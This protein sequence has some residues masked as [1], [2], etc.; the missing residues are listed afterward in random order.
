MNTHASAPRD[1][2]LLAGVAP[3][4]P[5]AAAPARSSRPFS[6]KKAR[7]DAAQSLRASAWPVRVQEIREHIEVQK[8]LS[9]L[10]IPNAKPQLPS[11]KRAAA[12]SQ[13]KPCMA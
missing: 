4:R 10:D 1:D 8:A 12:A 2:E 9:D 11:E 3:S 5:L 6:M 13:V 7:R